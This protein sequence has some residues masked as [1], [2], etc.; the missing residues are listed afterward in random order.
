MIDISN[1]LNQIH[2]IPRDNTLYLIE[3]L[4]CRTGLFVSN[5]NLFYLVPNQERC[6][7]LSI[8]TDFLHLETNVFV[9]VFNSKIPSFENDFYNTIELQLSDSNETEGNLNAFINMCL[10]HATYLRGDEFI[11]FFDSL[12]S[13]FQLPKEQHFK[14]LVGLMGELLFIEYIYHYHE[15]DISKYWHTDGPLSRIDFVCPFANFEVKTTSNGSL[16]FSIKHNQL[17]TD[18]E[19]TNLVAVV[20]EENNMGRTLG[21]LISQLLENPDYCNSM[22]FALNIEKEKRR[23]SP[24]EM[25]NRKFVLKKIYAYRAKDINPFN[26]VPDYIEELSYKLDLLAFSNVTF[27]SILPTKKKS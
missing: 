22:N 7:S 6:A 26:Y 13:L 19:K 12:V 27:P 17:F 23:V 14:N 16:C 2:T 4:P 25:S 8:K 24:T 15:L 3:K 20:I 1:I 21:E 9:S 5:G 11:S 18:S 10:A